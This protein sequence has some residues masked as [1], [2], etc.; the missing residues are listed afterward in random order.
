[1]RMKWTSRSR[2]QG[3]QYLA[4]LLPGPVVG[5]DPHPH[6]P[7]RLSPRMERRTGIPSSRAGCSLIRRRREV[8]GGVHLDQRLRT[9]RAFR[10]LRRKAPREFDVLYLMVARKATARVANGGGQVERA[11]D[12]QREG[13]P[14][15][16]ERCSVAGDQRAGQDDEVLVSKHVR[17][18]RGAI[19][20]YIHD[21]SMRNGY[22]PD[23]A[24]DGRCHRAGLDLD[25]PLPPPGGRSEG[26]L[27]YLP[28][29]CRTWMV[30]PKGEPRS[31]IA[32]DPRP[33]RKPTSAATI[34]R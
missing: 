26:E 25:G 15:H 20:A 10:K 16:R 4:H 27:V 29:R 32:V 2:S 34:R 31:V 18:R 17:D 12:P 7:A 1:M 8:L 30:T 19:L 14:L 22:A 6:P 23:R 24:R 3:L 13:G 21:Y 11:S 9:T 33:A 5:R 28:R